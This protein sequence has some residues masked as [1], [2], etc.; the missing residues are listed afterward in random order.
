M[1]MLSLGVLRQNKLAELS[2]IG[3]FT[4]FFYLLRINNVYIINE[5]DPKSVK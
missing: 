5:Q 4:L 1:S 3:H 2:D